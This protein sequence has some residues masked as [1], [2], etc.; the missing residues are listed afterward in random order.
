MY[1]S[2]PDPRFILFFDGECVMCNGLV[3][4]VA[5]HDPQ[6]HFAFASL[7]GE[8]AAAFRAR[9]PSFPRSLDTMVF[10]DDGDIRL[11]SDAA[12]AAA[13]LLSAP[14]RWLSLL[15]VLPTAL[16]DLGYRIVARYRL[17]WFGR[18]E[19]CWVPPLEDRRRLLP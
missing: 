8:T 11:R 3:A 6:R 14:W 17:R 7:Q 16:T 4:F 12:F 18:T 13:R 10:F 5:A 1:T 19:S 2:A 9:Y 15:R